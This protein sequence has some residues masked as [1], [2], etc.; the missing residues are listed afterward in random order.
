M[1]AHDLIWKYAVDV[2]VD[3][4][5][6]ILYMDC[7][8]RLFHGGKI[9]GN[10][11]FDSMNGNFISL[12]H[13]LVLMLCLPNAGRKLG[14]QQVGKVNCGKERAHYVLMALSCEEEWKNYKEVVKISSVRCLEIIV[15]KGSSPFM[16]CL[17]DNVDLEPKENLTKDEA[18]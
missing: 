2:G 15:D 7:L 5:L 4:L 3:V 16:P 1:K 17:D 9:K 18:L 12:V 13:L 10:E 11:E 6:H 14:G 8:V